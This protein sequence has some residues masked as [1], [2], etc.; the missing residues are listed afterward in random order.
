MQRPHSDT[1]WSQLYGIKGE[2]EKRTNQ[3]RSCCT[4]GAQ[5]QFVTL[6][7]PTVAGLPHVAAGAAG[8]VGTCGPL[9]GPVLCDVVVL[10]HA[11]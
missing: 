2:E 10:A 3:L 4:K 8:G 6:G 11:I 7:P 1:G 5:R 9:A